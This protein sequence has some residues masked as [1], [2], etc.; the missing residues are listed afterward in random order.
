MRYWELAGEVEYRK[1][2]WSGVILAGLAANVA[3]AGLGF[4]LDRR[5]VLAVR[6]SPAGDA[7]LV[8]IPARVAARPAQAERFVE[9]LA[10][11]M[12]GWDEDRKASNRAYVEERVTS[13]VLDRMARLV[14]AYE[15]SLRGRVVGRVDADVRVTRV[16]G[17]E[18]PFQ[19]EIHTDIEFSGEYTPPGLGEKDPRNARREAYA[20]LF[21]VAESARTPG[22]PAG[23]VVTD[24]ARVS[25]GALGEGTAR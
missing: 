2:L 18:A 21:T 24:M 5:P 15:V 1:L 8:E 11:R 23:L 6:T 10:S 4:A 25:L 16:I 9:Q 22:N 3:L 7:D 12:L 13:A 20:F 14:P 17:E 19:V